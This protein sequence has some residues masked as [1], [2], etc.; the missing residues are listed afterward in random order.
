ME[1]TPPPLP[2][3]PVDPST[4]PIPRRQFAQPQPFGSAKPPPEIEAAMGPSRGDGP[5]IDEA[6][7]GAAAV[8]L[9]FWQHPMVQNVLP[10][11]A[12]ALIHAGILLFAVLTYKVVIIVTTPTKEQ[13]TI[14]EAA[15][16]EEAEGGIPHPGING[17]AT[18]DAAQ[19]Q[20]P[21]VDTQ[22]VAEQKN[23][24]DLTQALGGGAGDAATDGL[25]AMGPN[26][27]LGRGKNA[28]T[29]Q[30]QGSGSGSGEGGGPLAAF[31][32]PGG[33]SGI[34]PKTKFFGVGGR[35]R[36]IVFVLDATGSMVGKFEFL[37]YQTNKALDILQPPQAFNI[38]FINDQNPT[39]PS[40]ALMFVTPDNKRLA[41]EYVDKAV[42]RGG[43]DPLPAL[44]KAFEM[45]PDLIYFFIDPGDFPDKQAV[46]SLVHKHAA[47]GKIKM[48]IIAFQH[49]DP[50][51]AK[52]L[53]NLAK[54]T[55]G[56]YR[57]LS[58]KELEQFQ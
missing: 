34:G 49:N 18:R 36:R 9:G 2:S 48:N 37:Q 14:P 57:F 54:E 8:H 35:A 23:N 19:D 1:P 41:K 30:G 51:N 55:G 44:T 56:V 46:L 17:D 43:T 28:N 12:S 5:T 42:S 33:G 16:T 13:V 45:K 40:P 21:N 3:T 47:D 11:V 15:M 52:F 50:E 39:P 58:E 10:L 24:N 22:G 26:A 31:G 53:S 6:A 7:G 25:V 27:L 32:V 29:G 38:I 20:V 4:P